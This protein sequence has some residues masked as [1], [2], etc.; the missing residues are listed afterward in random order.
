MSFIIID[1]EKQILDAIRATER[2]NRE[3]FAAAVS[4]AEERALALTKSITT[5]TICSRVS[6]KPFLFS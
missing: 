5:R 6:T 3:V 2:E 4:R 1:Q